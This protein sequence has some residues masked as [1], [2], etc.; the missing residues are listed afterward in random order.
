MLSNS[1]LLAASISSC[2]TCSCRI[3]TAS[4]FLQQIKKD[5]VIGHTPVVILSAVDELPKVLACIEAGAEDYLTKPFNPVLM[6]S[7]VQVL[8]EP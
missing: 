1:S 3:W 4:P 5:P 7:R 8:L 2:L 6:R